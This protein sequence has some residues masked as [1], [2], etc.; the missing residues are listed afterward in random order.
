MEE[1]YEGKIYQVLKASCTNPEPNLCQTG[2]HYRSR[3]SHRKSR[4]K[5]N[6]M[7]SLSS[8]IFIGIG[9]T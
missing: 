8:Y 3:K 6:Q 7:N 4:T 9:K 2:R 1:R 5:L